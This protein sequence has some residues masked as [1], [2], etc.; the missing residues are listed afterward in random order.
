MKLKKI[1]RSVSLMV[2]GSF[3]DGIKG[4]FLIFDGVEGSVIGQY[5]LKQMQ[6]VLPRF[7]G[8]V[9]DT[10]DADTIFMQDNAPIHKA[11][12]VVNWLQ[13]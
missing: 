8:Y 1:E 10:L 13:E 6:E 12:I 3:A 11:E 7:M 9:A 5:Y 2:W 4:P